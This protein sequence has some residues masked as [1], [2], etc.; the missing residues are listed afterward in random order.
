M[1]FSN[2]SYVAFGNLEQEQE[3]W[4]RKK[5]TQNGGLAERDRHQEFASTTG[6]LKARKKNSERRRRETVLIT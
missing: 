4:R 1:V 6:T 2:V 3:M 5:E